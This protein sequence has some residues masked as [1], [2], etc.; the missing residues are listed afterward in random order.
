[1][2][3]STMDTKVI[4]QYNSRVGFTDGVLLGFNQRN[5]YKMAVINGMPVI[6]V[7]THYSNAK[8][9]EVRY[10]FTRKSPDKDTF[11]EFFGCLDE[12][13][14][15]LL[16]NYRLGNCV[17]VFPIYANAFNINHSFFALIDELVS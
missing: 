8:I 1:M 14:A 16:V 11:P 17:V 13:D 12:T 7:K 4:G 10:N 5:L 2:F 3:P 6:V 9:E 15:S